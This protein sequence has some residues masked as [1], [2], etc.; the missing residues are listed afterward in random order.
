MSQTHYTNRSGCSSYCSYEDSEDSGFEMSF[1]SESSEVVDDLFS[2]DNY[3]EKTESRSK[4]KDS[5]S[6]KLYEKFN[7][8]FYK[9]LNECE[10]KYSYTSSPPNYRN[11][12]QDYYETNINTYDD[13]LSETE[14]CSSQF[15]KTS[16]PTKNK[17]FEKRDN[18]KEEKP[19]RRYATGRNRVSRAKS[20]TQ[21][22]R[23]RRHRRMKANDRER[24]RMHIL[25]EALDRLRC[26]LPTFPEDTKL[27]KIETLRFAY[28]YIWALSQTVNNVDKFPIEENGNVI[29]NVG[30]VTVSINREGNT[31]TAKNY[32]QAAPNAVVTEGSINN[33][34]FMQE[35][36]YEDK[37]ET[38]PYWMREPDNTFSNPSYQ[39]ASYTNNY[40]SDNKMQCLDNM[41]YE[42]I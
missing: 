4:F 30:N 40:Y 16:T 26:V 5:H 9:S 37:H 25:N 23:I 7:E 20:P 13:N 34:S 38:P 31:I 14:F 10:N 22:Q 33:A 15:L 11:E 3:P 36:N 12:R 1:K 42:C 8:A 41:T 32:N 17:G 24:N 19:K 21:I 29:V 2:Y 27:T 28:S 18:C 6:Q 39:N 35:F